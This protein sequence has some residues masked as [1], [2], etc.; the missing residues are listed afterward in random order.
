M[1]TT[2][3]AAG[4]QN[5]AGG[6]QLVMGVPQ[7]RWMVFVRE[8]PNLKWMMIWGYPH[9]W[10]PPA[11]FDPSYTVNP[12]SSLLEGPHAGV[13][14]IDIYIPDM[15]TILVGHIVPYY[16]EFGHLYNISDC[17]LQYFHYIPTIFQL[18]SR[19]TVIFSY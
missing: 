12:E 11:C 8:N 13:L 17:G 19:H 2:E 14:V 9:L 10:K 18:L 4:A 5:P 3:P 6:F 1:Q 15:F 7:V 16:P